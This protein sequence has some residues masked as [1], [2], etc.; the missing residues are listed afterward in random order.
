MNIFFY[1]PC[2]SVAA[3][4]YLGQLLQLSVLKKL[5]ILPTGPLFH[6]RLALKLR[7]GDLLLLF[8]ANEDELDPLLRLRNELNDFCIIVILT[9]TNSIHR[10]YTL[11][12]R[13]VVFHNEDTI[14]LEDFVEKKVRTKTVLKQKIRQHNM[15]QKIQK[16]QGGEKC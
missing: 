12:P 7:N 14:K 5:M 15:K 6:S 9:G 2:E 10:A 4:H 13:F 3:T 1:T 11:Q 16:H 8:V